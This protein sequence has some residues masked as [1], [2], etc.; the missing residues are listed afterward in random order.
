[1]SSRLN[2]ICCKT[3]TSNMNK[4][5]LRGHPWWTPLYRLKGSVRVPLFITAE[6]VF[7]Y[8]TFTQ[9]MKSTPKFIFSKVQKPFQNLSV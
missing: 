9:F 3:C 8:S 5:A 2:N 1:M 6:L 4:S 7:L